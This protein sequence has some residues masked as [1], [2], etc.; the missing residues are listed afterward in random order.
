MNHVMRMAAVLTVGA[1]LCAGC[2]EDV[3]NAP[4]PQ[5][6]TSP[7]TSSAA[8]GSHAH[9]GEA[10]LGTKPAGAY[11]VKATQTGEYTDGEFDAEITGGPGRPKAVRFWIGPETGGDTA[12][13]DA[14]SDDG[15]HWHGHPKVPK[16][17]PQGAQ[18][19]VEVEPP[20]GPAARAGFDLKQ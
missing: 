20:T 13:A 19:W 5:P 14:S 11:Q 3:A 2:K 10:V 6:A 9:E 1:Y 12:R 4:A 17:L 8:G 7:A 15:T 18:F 16:T